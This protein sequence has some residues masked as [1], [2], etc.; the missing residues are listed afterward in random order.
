[1]ENPNPYY[2]YGHPL[3]DIKF[4]SWI[5]NI[6]RLHNMKRI[7]DKHGMRMRFYDISFPQQMEGIQ[8]HDH[9]HR[10]WVDYYIYLSI[11]PEREQEFKK[12]HEYVASN[13]NTDPKFFTYDSTK[14]QQLVT[15]LKK[16]YTKVLP[17]DDDRHNFASWIRYSGSTPKPPKCDCDKCK[18]FDD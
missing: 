1:M 6:Q 3:E 11:T 7:F 17:E 13:N 5:E 14:I 18:Q 8:N 4:H 10:D 12:L 15:S 2:R 9:L 16:W